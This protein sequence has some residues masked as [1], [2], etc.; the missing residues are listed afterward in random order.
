M[1]LCNC[2]PPCLPEAVKENASRAGCCATFSGRLGPSTV[3][4]H[5]NP[6][7]RDRQGTEEIIVE[8]VWHIESF[9]I[10]PS[11]LTVCHCCEHMKLEATRTDSRSGLCTGLGVCTAV[12]LWPSLQSVFVCVCGSSCSGRGCARL[13]LLLST[14]N[15]VEAKRLI[16]S[17]SP[18]FGT[19]S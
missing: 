11:Y 2:E 1:G 18:L 12:I 14:C 9:S 6:Q 4:F 13:T 10:L 15:Q 5:I 7:V 3:C 8:A 19:I 16:P 17:W